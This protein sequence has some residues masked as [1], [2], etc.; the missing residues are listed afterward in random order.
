MPRWVQSQHLDLSTCRCGICSL[1]YPV[2]LCLVLG[3]WSGG[4]QSSA[5]EALA[6]GRAVTVVTLGMHL[7]ARGRD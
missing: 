4:Q 3:S 7:P 5:N 1:A 2:F 6:E